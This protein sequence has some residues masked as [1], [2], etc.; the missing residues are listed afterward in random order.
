MRK[1]KRNERDFRLLVAI[2]EAAEEYRRRWDNEGW[3]MASGEHALWAALDALNRAPNQSAH[4]IQVSWCQCCELRVENDHVC[5]CETP[6]RGAE[7]R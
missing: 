6:A 4:I 5:A 1:L 2:A 3:E 7:R